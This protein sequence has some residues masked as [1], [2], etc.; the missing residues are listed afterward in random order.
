[1]IVAS[2]NA[3][4]LNFITRA[5]LFVLMVESRNFLLPVADG[6]LVIRI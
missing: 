4:F 6:I 5:F 1:M 2:V 3:Q